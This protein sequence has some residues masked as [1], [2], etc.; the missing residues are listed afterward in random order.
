VAGLAAGS[1][2]A[3]A[4][5]GP[6]DVRPAFALGCVATLLAAALALRG[7]GRI[8]EAIAERVGRGVT[9]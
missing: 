1:A 9:V 6:R 4:L 3:G 7:R 2:L 8:E 5:V